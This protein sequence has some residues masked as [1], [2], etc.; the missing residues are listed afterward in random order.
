MAGQGVGTKSEKMR[1]GSWG[2]GGVGKGGRERER[3]E[4]R[5]RGRWKKG[6][7]GEALIQYAAGVGTEKVTNYGSRSHS[8]F[9][10]AH[11][12]G[13]MQYEVGPKPA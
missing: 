2:R 5:T 6:G 9:R 8:V 7:G 10:G 11:F 4:K 13:R 12:A 1:Q 3:R